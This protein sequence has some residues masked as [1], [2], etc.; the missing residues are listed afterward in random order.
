[1]ELFVTESKV[2]VTHIHPGPIV[3]Q[4]HL[5]LDLWLEQLRHFFA[6]ILTWMSADS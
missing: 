4:H 1:M 3:L 6:Q 2:L 5:S